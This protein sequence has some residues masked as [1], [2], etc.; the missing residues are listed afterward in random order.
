MTASGCDS[1]SES[2][3][4]PATP[5]P[6]PAQPSQPDA[7]KPKAP[8]PTPSGPQWAFDTDPVGTTPAG[9]ERLET[10][11]VGHPATW[12]VVKDVTAPSGDRVFGVLASTNAGQTYNLALAPDFE[13]TDVDVSVALKAVSGSEDQGGGVVFRARGASDYYIAR[14]NPLEKNARFY[15]V[16]N[17][18]R[19]AFAVVELDL[20]PKA[21]HTL[22][23]IAEGPRMELFMDEESVLVANDETHSGPGRIGLWTKADAATLF[24]DLAAQ[25]L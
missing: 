15:V 18:Q 16:D 4:A 12:G 22:R 17:E 2:A 24:D 14:W 13:T 25:P 11:S 10:A 19:S 7:A 1:Q 20:E 3:A 6:P 21:W 8:S 9:F 5:P 23:V